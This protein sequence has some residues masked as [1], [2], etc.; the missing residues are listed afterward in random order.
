MSD[1][2]AQ[3][4]IKPLRNNFVER[5]WG[6]TRIRAFKGMCPLPDQREIAGAGIGEAFE[7]AAFDDDYESAKFPS[8][9]RL[10]D[11]SVQSLPELFAKRGHELLGEAFVERFGP[12][13]PLLPKT[14]DV[15]ELLSVQG[16]PVGNTEVYLI[17]DAE[18]GATI[19]LGFNRDI[20]PD[21]LAPVLIGGREK[22]QKLVDMLAAGVDAARLQEALA[23]WMARSRDSNGSA[24]PDLTGLLI[25]SADRSAV[26][27]LVL[28]LRDIYW[29]MLDSMNAL[30][31][32]P[33]QVIH[34]ANPPRIV[35]MTGVPATAEVHA[36]GNPEGLEILALEVRRPGTTLRA[37]DNVRF[38]MR[39]VAVVDALEVLNLH[40]TEPAEFLAERAPVPGRDRVSVSID[41][42]YFRVEHLCP[43]AGEPAT[44]PAEQ[45]HS[46][47][48]IKGSV[49]LENE[50]GRIVGELEGGESAIVPIGVGAYTVYARDG[51]PEVARVSLPL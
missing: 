46:L 5:P 7:I 20:D 48:A 38:P 28:D 6:G 2:L 34:N 14:L 30:E 10:E 25:E 13:F 11:G 31:V 24:I 51:E 18:P 43:V 36:L 3:R 33:G 39:D 4:I 32:V 50:K 47:H 26:E 22:Q 15:L 40:K 45:P 1:P 35:E 27:G 29:Q 12:C 41:S 42:E 23:P 9:V 21:A 8:L 37:W 17:I 49:Y 16:H 44:V 19:R